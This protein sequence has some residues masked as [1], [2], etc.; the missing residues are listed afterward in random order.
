[1]Y[2]SIIGLVLD[3]VGVILIYYFGLLPLKMFHSFLRDH[4]VSD[5]TVERYH[6]I[7]GIGMILLVLGFVFQII[8]TL[9]TSKVF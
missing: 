5:E 9:V 6:K 2:Y 7:S 4:T 1:M 8:G 3:I